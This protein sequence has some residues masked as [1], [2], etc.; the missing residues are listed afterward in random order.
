MSHL[1]LKIHLAYLQLIFYSLLKTIL[2]EAEHWDSVIRQF[3]HLVTADRPIQAAEEEI[4]IAVTVDVVEAGN[5]LAIRKDRLTGDI[6]NGISN[7]GKDRG[8]GRTVVAEVLH[9]AEAP[10][11]QKVEITVAVEVDE[12]GPLPHRQVLISVR[13]PHELRSGRSADVL[14]QHQ[15]VRAFLKEE[16]DV[17][18]TVDVGELGTGHVEATEKRRVVRPAV[19]VVY[20]KRIDGARELGRPSQGL[21]PV[22]PDGRR[23]RSGAPYGGR[24]TTARHGDAGRRQHARTQASYQTHPPGSLLEPHLPVAITC[25]GRLSFRIRSLPVFQDTASAALS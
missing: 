10:L 1:Y 3:G 17:P 2:Q 15:L 24:P 9:I 8:L 7:G 4:Q 13:A 25:M 16:V 6:P 23:D 21:L 12:A 19:L 5:V 20:G 18:I 22:G 11:A 14:E